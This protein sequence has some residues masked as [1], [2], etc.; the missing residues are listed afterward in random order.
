MP[1]PGSCRLSRDFP[2][3]FDDSDA[4]EA[5]RLLESVGAATVECTDTRSELQA[6]ARAF[7]ERG[8]TNVLLVSSPTHLPRCLRDAPAAFAAEHYRP[9]TVLGAASDTSYAGARV[10]DVAI[11]EPPHRPDRRADCEDPELALHRLVARALRVPTER[12]V[13][14]ARALHEVLVGFGA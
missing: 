5:A 12:R 2:H 13:D 1:S 10:A 9:P 8:V 7:A 6:A 4:R 11:V 14:F 3:A